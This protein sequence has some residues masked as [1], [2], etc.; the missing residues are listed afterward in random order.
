MA[1]DAEYG[2][3]LAETVEASLVPLLQSLEPQDLTTLLNSLQ[4]IKDP[5][6]QIHLLNLLPIYPASVAKFRQSLAKQFLGVSPTA[7]VDDLL[8]FLRTKYPFKELPRDISNTQIQHI[9][10]AILVFDI[11][12]SFPPREEADVVR[13]VIKELQYM[14]R[15]IIDGRAAFIVRTEAKEIIQRLW[16]RLDYS[17][18][19]ISG[20]REDALTSYYHAL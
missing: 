6:L 3:D 19:P 11:A 8:T 18:N 16:L 9:K 10:A 4:I 2:P 1:M 15:S 7:P 14:H 17:V 12:I 13:K 5:S 20:F